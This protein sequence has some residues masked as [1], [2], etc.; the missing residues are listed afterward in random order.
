MLILPING[1][2]LNK[3][4]SKEKNEEY[5]VI[6]PY[7]TERFKKVF[8]FDENG[9]PIEG[10]IKEV[11]LR[12]GYRKDSPSIIANVSLRYGHGHPEMG[13]VPGNETD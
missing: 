6:K 9:V 1:Y 12:A 5:R 7:W 3:I 11:M 8:E 10:C 4:I 2:W 13:A